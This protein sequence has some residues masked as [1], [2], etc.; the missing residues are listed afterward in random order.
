MKSFFQFLTEATASQAASQAK[1]LGL[2]GDG[3]GGWLDRSGKTVAR[4]DQG[5]LKFID[6]RKTPTEPIVGRQP[7]PSPA[8]LPTQTAQT[9]A[10]PQPQI[11]PQGETQQEPKEE[12]SPITI[13]FGRI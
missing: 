7:S 11:T 10:S 2:R 8:P 9:P 12:T 6:G 4:T 3:H 1:K 5:K 13:V